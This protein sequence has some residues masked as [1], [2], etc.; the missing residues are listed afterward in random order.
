MLAVSARTLDRLLAPWRGARRRRG[1]TKPGRGLRQSIPLRGAWTEEGPGGLELDTV[2][3]CGGTLDDRHLWRLDA[4]DIRTD[5]TEPRALENRG[6]HCTVTQ[7]QDLEASLPF[8]LLGVDSDNGGEF[9][10]HPVV[11]GTGQ[12]PKPVLF[13]RSRPYHKNDHAHVEQRNWTQVRQ[14]LGDERYDHPPAGPRLNARGKGARGRLQNHFLPPHKLEKKVRPHGRP[15]RGY[16]GA[17][18]PRARVRAAP[19]VAGERKVELK[20]LHARRNP[21]PLHRDSERQ[22]KE[23]Q[24]LRLFPA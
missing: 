19:Q 3:L 14:Q 6:P 17:Q 18:T 11:A 2:A 9:S 23:I 8:P 13:P 21:F 24:A 15:T 12:R 10:N 16:G 5:W 1:G 20:T 22:K 7:L 4:V